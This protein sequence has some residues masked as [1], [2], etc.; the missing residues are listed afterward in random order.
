MFLF[1]QNIKYIFSYRNKLMIK[2]LIYSTATC[3]N[4]SVDYYAIWLLVQKICIVYANWHSLFICYA[5][6]FCMLHTMCVL[7]HVCVYVFMLF[8]IEYHNR[9]VH[10]NK[11]SWNVIQVKN[12]EGTHFKAHKRVNHRT[13]YIRD[14]FKD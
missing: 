10:G 5:G 6:E 14:H 1:L 13:N 12:N 9:R 3:E 11:Y 4:K 8:R 7:L 2:H